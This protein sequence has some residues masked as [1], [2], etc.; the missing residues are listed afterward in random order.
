[1]IGLFCAII[2]IIIG[3]PIYMIGCDNKIGGYC[4]GYV[5]YTAQ[6]IDNTCDLTSGYKSS[7][8]GKTAIYDTIGY[9]CN[10]HVQYIENGNNITCPIY[11]SDSDYC[12]FV[13]DWSQYRKCNKLNIKDYPVGSSHII[14]VNRVDGRCE[15]NH[16]VQNNTKNINKVIYC[17]LEF[18]E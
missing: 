11:R 15:T 13:T 1:M 17:K 12:S 14:N 18:C 3:L 16:I 6:V 9:N 5:K 7:G 4:N 10:V 2:F 8:N